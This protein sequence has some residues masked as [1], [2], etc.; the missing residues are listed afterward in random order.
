MT[1]TNQFTTFL[2]ITGLSDHLGAAK[3]SRL[4]NTDISAFNLINLI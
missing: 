2:L 4:R 1:P 3:T